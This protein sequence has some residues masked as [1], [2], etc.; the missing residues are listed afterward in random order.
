MKKKF[1]FIAFVVSIL[2][3]IAGLTACAG[4][5]GTE[6]KGGEQTET[7][8]EKEVTIK[9]WAYPRW[10]GITGSEKDGKL[11]DWEQDA[12]KR[13][14]EKYPNVKIETEFLNPQGG[15]EKVAIAIQTNSMPDVLEDS[16]IRFFEY[17][18]KGLLVPIGDYLDK[19]DIE[20]YYENIWANTTIG[21]GKHYYLPWGVSPQFVM[22][23]KSLFSQ[24]GIESLL[25]Q[26]EDRT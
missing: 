23:N 14:M 7:T 9:F 12:A 3:V 4:K 18:H 20:D 16:E 10:N 2:I 25:P 15:P 8:K 6:T 17:A 5:S 11:G 13:F 21:D 1:R 24:A 22:I 26:N 19:S